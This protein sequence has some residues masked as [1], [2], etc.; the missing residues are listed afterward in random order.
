MGVSKI[1]GSPVSADLAMPLNE[2]ICEVKDKCSV[3]DKNDGMDEVSISSKQNPGSPSGG[4]YF[5][6]ASS[7][8][9]LFS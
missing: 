1:N 4:Y 8:L 2:T 3:L 5:L 9:C 7:P 6:Q